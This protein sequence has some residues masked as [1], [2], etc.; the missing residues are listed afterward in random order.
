MTS[1]LAATFQLVM[2]L[3]M[4]CGGNGGVSLIPVVFIGGFVVLAYQL[5]KPDSALRRRLQQFWYDAAED[6]GIDVHP[7]GRR[8]YLSGVVDDLPLEVRIVG[9]G[10]FAKLVFRAEADALPATAFTATPRLIRGAS[11]FNEPANLLEIGDPAFDAHYLIGAKDPDTARAWLVP[12]RLDPLRVLLETFDEVPIGGGAV[13]A[14]SKFDTRSVWQL[15]TWARQVVR[16][17]G[18]FVSVEGAPDQSP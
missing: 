12:M 7:I 16:A 5:Y 17:T 13:R 8:V 14:E 18:R 6:L 3:L 15:A 1:D 4:A 9:D 2:M 10:A 11:I